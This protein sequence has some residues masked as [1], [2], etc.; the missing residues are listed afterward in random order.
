MSLQALWSLF[1][2]QPAPMLNGLALFFGLAGGWLLLAT[3]WREQRAALRMLAD[4]DVHEVVE[5]AS[6]LDEPTLRLNR[7]FYRF[8]SASLGLALALSW[9]STQ[10]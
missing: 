6:L 5:L 3:R 2:A 1:L 10:L 9:A 7:F 8:G 4:S